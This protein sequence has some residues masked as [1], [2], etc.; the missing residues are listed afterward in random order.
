MSFSNRSDALIEQ[1]CPAEVSYEA[2]VT[3]GQDPSSIKIF[4]VERQATEWK[5]VGPIA[6][7]GV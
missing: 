2:T 4:H 3:F 6:T 7:T 1:E 5:R